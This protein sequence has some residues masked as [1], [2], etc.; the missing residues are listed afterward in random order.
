MQRKWLHNCDAAADTEASNGGTQVSQTELLP[1]KLPG[2]WCE[3]NCVSHT[4][5]SRRVPSDYNIISDIELTR[6]KWRVAAAFARGSG[7][8]QLPFLGIKHSLFVQIAD[9]QPWTRK[10]YNNAVSALRRAFDFGYLDY[11]ERR[12]P[13]LK[14]SRIGKKD[15]PPIDP[16]S[17]Q[18]AE[19]LIAA[20]HQDWGDLQGDHDELRF[21]AGLRPS[22][23]IALVVTD[24]DR[25]HGALSVTKAHVRH[26][27]R[28]HEDSL[29]SSGRVVSTGDC[30]PEAARASPRAML[31]RGTHPSRAPAFHRRGHPRSGCEIPLWSLAQ[32]VQALRHPLSQ[33]VCGPAY[34]GELE[35]GGWPQ[36]AADRHHVVGVRRLDRRRSGG[37]HRG[38]L[39]GR[40]WWR[41]E[42]FFAPSEPGIRPPKPS[43]LSRATPLPGHIP[44]RGEG[45][46]LPDDS[47]PEDGSRPHL[48]VARCYW[49]ATI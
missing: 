45:S 1:A 17:I 13:A 10:K 29:R 27:S 9:S 33:A 23:E 36:S 40:E 41:S 11:P 19:V 30:D 39:G 12:N 20:L 15:R 37:R 5:T 43:P 18:D 49:W 31:P 32:H 38:H 42:S 22:E 3:S 47:S 48:P 44:V 21:F 24:Y 34:F 7:V 35:F 2:K 4:A 26:R 6:A 28:R 8:G 25:V 46:A 16:F 14:C